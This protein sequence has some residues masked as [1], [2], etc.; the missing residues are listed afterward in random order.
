MPWLSDPSKKGPCV[1]VLMLC[2]AY[3]V[4]RVI[5]NFFL[6]RPNPTHVPCPHMPCCGQC[7]RKKSRKAFFFLFLNFIKS[8]YQIVGV[9]FQVLVLFLVHVLLFKFDKIKNSEL[10]SIFNANKLIIV[11][12]YN[13][14]Y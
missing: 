5:L 13:I 3:Y 4:F 11:R 7:L 1:L 12:E 14:N 10:K 8:A 2:R 9:V 6:F